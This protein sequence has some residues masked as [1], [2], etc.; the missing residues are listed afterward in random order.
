MAMRAPAEM[1]MEIAMKIKVK[2]QAQPTVNKV[3]KAHGGNTM[4]NQGEDEHG[5]EE[6]DKHEERRR[7]RQGGGITNVATSP[8]MKIKMQ[9]K[10][11]TEEE[12]GHE[13]T[14]DD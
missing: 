7:R 13:A 12:H 6:T 14:D 9:I 1:G 10:M 3:T 4:K 2:E 5:V 8:K 11:R